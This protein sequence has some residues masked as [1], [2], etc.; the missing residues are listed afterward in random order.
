V[1]RMSRCGLCLVSC[2]VGWAAVRACVGTGGFPNFHVDGD[3]SSCFLCLYMEG[4]IIAPK[5]RMVS[6]I[7]QRGRQ[8]QRFGS[9]G[10]AGFFLPLPCLPRGR[11]VL[12][13]C[14]GFALQCELGNESCGIG[15]RRGATW[16]VDVLGLRWSD[17]AVGFTSVELCSGGVEGLIYISSFF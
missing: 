15:W 3:V 2:D 17:A 9:A 5:C 4:I 10:G 1:L 8:R 7:C 12:F 14:S 6:S 11:P 16:K 13:Q